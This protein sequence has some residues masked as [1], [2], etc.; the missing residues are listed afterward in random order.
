M[1]ALLWPLVTWL[2]REVIIKFV[3]L[4]TMFLLVKVFSDVAIGYLTGWMDTSGISGAFGNLPAFV[5][6]F[7]SVFK[8]DVGIQL[9]LSAYATRF[10]I[11]RLPVVG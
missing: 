10:L 7:V 11:R 1:Q 2:V 6:Y 3:V 4:T 9:M 5:W 8:I